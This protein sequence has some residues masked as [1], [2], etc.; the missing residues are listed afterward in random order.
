MI[1]RLGDTIDPKHISFLRQSSPPASNLLGIIND[2]PR[3]F[4]NRKPAR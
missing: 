2:I 4:E 3:S 1:D